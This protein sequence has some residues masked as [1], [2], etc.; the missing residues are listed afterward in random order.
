VDTPTY[1]PND[2]DPLLANPLFLGQPQVW[3]HPISIFDEGMANGTFST[4][5]YEP[6]LTQSQ[7]AQSRLLLPQ[8]DW[9]YNEEPLLAYN[10]QATIPVRIINPVYLQSAHVLE[11][12]IS[13]PRHPSRSHMISHRKVAL[14][15]SP[16]KGCRCWMLLM[17]HHA[18]RPFAPFIRQLRVGPYLPSRSFHMILQ[19]QRKRVTI[20]L[21]KSLQPHSNPIPSNSRNL[22]DGP[23]AVPWQSTG[24]YRLSC[25]V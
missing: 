4:Q 19:C 16:P 21:G 22:A 12:A 23:E 2:W 6:D 9:G 7:L 18:T 1:C 17:A 13:Q 3:E 20:D 11:L 10:N 8:F 14:A 5:N 15:Q 24:S 25:T